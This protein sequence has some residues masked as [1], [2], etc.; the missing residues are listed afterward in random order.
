VCLILFLFLFV[1]I[2]FYISDWLTIYDRAAQQKWHDLLANAR[3]AEK[4]PA[5]FASI[6]GKLDVIE[7]LQSEAQDVKELAELS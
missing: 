1:F 4:D 7:Y 5:F 6:S 3:E 2:C